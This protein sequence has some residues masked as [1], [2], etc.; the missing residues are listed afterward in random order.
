[1]L[2]LTKG[3]LPKV[4]PVT[5]KE[6]LKAHPNIIMFGYTFTKGKRKTP[7]KGQYK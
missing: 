7:L 2:A 4:L 1:M 6:S 3:V 5:K